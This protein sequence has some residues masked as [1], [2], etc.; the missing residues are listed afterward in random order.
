MRILFCNFEYPPLGGGGGVITAMIAREMAKHHDVTVLTSKGLGLP[1]ER[2]EG[3]VRVV[4]VPV[5]FRKQEAVANL[6]SMFAYLPMGIL[7]GNRLIRQK[8]FDIIN[9]H[10]VLPTGPVGDYLSRHN[11]IPNVLTI[12]G[13]DLYD[14]TKWTSPHKHALLT[15]WVKILLRRADAVVTQS[16]NTSENMRHFYCPD[17]Q[18]VRIPLAIQKPESGAASRKEYGFAEDEIL[19]ATIGRVVTRK[20]I[21]QL[22]SMTDSMRQLKVR[23]LIIGTGPK[24]S[25]LKQE[26]ENRGLSEKVSFLGQVE[27]REKFRILRMSD[28]YVSTSQHEG[29]GIVFVEAMACGLPVVCYD[30][31][32]QTDFLRDA[33]TGYIVSLNDLKRFEDRCRKLAED[34]ELRQKMGRENIKKAESFF[35]ESC[36][37]RYEETFSKVM[38][39]FQK[40]ASGRRDR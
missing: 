29:F 2:L 25:I 3:G 37:A 20:A 33:E 12:H 6:S 19:F 39:N 28:I 5:W 18:D 13:G 10:F 23:L 26:V 40:N 24:E 22:I 4:R 21:D 38:E 32:G 36:A 11:N 1:G 16:S 7:Y 17:L 31:G 34:R 35:I 8:P 14:P 15:L 9:T 30:N 27:E